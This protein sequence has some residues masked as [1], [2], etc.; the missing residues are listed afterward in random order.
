MNHCLPASLEDLTGLRAARWFRESTAGQ[1]DNFG[2]DAQ[3][4]QQDR[5]ISR[6]GLMDS[7]LEWSVAS[8]GWKTAW[9]TPTWQAM[10][11]AAQDR[12]FDI[13]V[14]GYVSRFLRNLKQTLIAVEDHLQPA[15]VAV[16]FADERLLTSDPND[17]DQ[18][19]RE[20][21]EAE[22]YSRKLSRRVHEGY[23]GKRRRLGVPGGNRAPF[24]IVREGHPSVLRI[25][26]SR[27]AIVRHAY[28][29]AATG[30]T[31]WQVAG[32]TALKK[33]HVGE[34][35]TNPIY[36]GRLRTGEAAG[37][38]PIIEPGLWSR[39]QSARERRRTRTPGR[40]VKRNYALSLR[41]LGCGRFLFGDVGR[42]R[43]PAPT[44][45]AFRSAT[46]A[47]LDRRAKG[48]SYQQ[49]WYED[50]VGTLL[51]TI[52]SVDDATISEVVRLHDAYQPKADELGLARI[53]KE[54][55]EAGR[56]LAL[57]R[58]I[59]AWQASMTRLDA[60]EA[61]ARQP[62]DAPRLTPLEIVDYLRSLPSLWADSGPDGRQA[63]M[64]AIFA[65]TDVLGFRRLEY[66]LTE[67][68]IELGLDAA[69]PHVIELG[70]KV[71]G[72]GRGERSRADG[73][74]VFVQIVGSD[75]ASPT[76]AR[77]SA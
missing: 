55:E 28:E 18:F 15:G 51:G 38:T 44:C 70:S 17:W 73:L 50:A 74:R 22:A 9:Q 42:Y 69:L 11:A 21:H 20:A 62:L 49:T 31:D 10:I 60:A 67:D 63:L 75:A 45:D 4:E 47:G 23:E 43:H 54:R 33:T 29:L 13:L 37:I 3:R 24:G 5:A 53:A 26:E 12:E 59:I 30:A 66:E 56:K 40:I 52:G 64:S 34:I 58:D 61:L 41:C 19:V 48:H 1:Y 77:R 6:Y 76:K 68:A 35:L 8:S 57:T 14:V 25:D 16:L 39:V 36:A 72:F 71:G 32:A 27:A 2:P 7:G 65:R 46:P